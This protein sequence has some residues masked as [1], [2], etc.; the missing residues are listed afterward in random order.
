MREVEHDRRNCQALFPILGK[1]TRNTLH[2]PIIIAHGIKPAAPIALGVFRE[3]SF[4]FLEGGAALG[5]FG[6]R[7]FGGGRERFGTCAGFRLVWHKLAFGRER[8]S[9]SSAVGL[10][11]HTIDIVDSALPLLTA[12]DLLRRILYRDDNMIILD[13]P[14][15]I[16]V[17]KARGEGQNLE[18]MFEF[19]RFGLG[20][21]PA[22]AHRLDKDTSGCLVLGRSRKALARLGMLFSKGF[23]EKSYL[24]VVIGSPPEHGVIAHRL[25]RASS[26]KRSWVMKASPDGDEALTHFQRLAK[27]D[28]VAVLA[29]QPKT[30]RTH[31]LRVHAATEGFPIAG[32][33]LYGGDRALAAARHLQLHA[34]RITIP[35]DRR[36][37][38]S[39]EAPLPPHMEPLLTL[40]GF[41]LEGV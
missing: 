1:I 24:A 41:T 3:F 34:S 19:L 20:R 33:R 29:M 4:L 15:G 10:S 30:G 16:A 8:P 27:G 12:D 6:K 2:F 25:A 17:H 28:G 22:L 31:Q 32:D 37:P 5:R 18:S 13:K 36:A 21:Q 7:A 38:V 23:V 14:A 40:A 9:R 39:V 26:D 11:P 35:F